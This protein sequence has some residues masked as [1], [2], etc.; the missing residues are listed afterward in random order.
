MWAVGTIT[1]QLTLFHKGT[2][3]TSGFHNCIGSVRAI[4]F[5]EVSDNF[6]SGD[7][8]GNLYIT[9]ISK[10]KCIFS[11]KHGHDEPIE[12]IRYLS[13]STI[14][15]GDTG[16]SVKIWDIRDGKCTRTFKYDNDFIADIAVVDNN[17]III[18]NSCGVTSVV[19]ISQ[20][21]R[22]EYYQ[23]EDDDFTSL[24]Y[25]PLNTRI[26]VS[27]SRPKIYCVKYPSLDYLFDVTPNTHSSIV[28]VRQIPSQL[29][30]IVTTQEDGSVSILNVHPNRPIFA[31]RAHKETLLGS[32][33]SGTIL[34]TWANDNTAKLWDIAEKSE[35]AYSKP[36]SGKKR[37]TVRVLEE[38]D[39]FFA[40]LVKQNVD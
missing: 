24:T 3:E 34:M 33:A 10:E 25:N 31:F 6:A 1:G 40:A 23:Q 8:S 37:K 15:V 14:A 7:K 4:E 11:Q 5:N 12:C 13:S 2:N 35:M 38:K 28:M 20:N 18:C 27:S 21:K 29:E 26:I 36:K 16:G 17:N 22:I 9:D 32:C 39:D 19:R 30:R